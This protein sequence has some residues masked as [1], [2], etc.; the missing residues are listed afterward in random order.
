MVAQIEKYYLHDQV[1]LSVSLPKELLS[2]FFREALSTFSLYDLSNLGNVLIE[3]A[4]SGATIITRNDGTTDFLIK[5]NTNGFLIESP[6]QGADAIISLLTE[7]GKKERLSGL[8]KTAANSI[9]ETWE[10]RAGKEIKLIEN[11]ITTHGK[12]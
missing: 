6:E 8:I 7:P 2:L 11:A 12:K 4:M 1:K 9:F 10:E 3:A 5:H